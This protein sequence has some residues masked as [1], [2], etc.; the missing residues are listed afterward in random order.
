MTR[1]DVRFISNEEVDT[2]RGLAAGNDGC[3]CAID[4]WRWGMRRNHIRVR[5]MALPPPRNYVGVGMSLGTGF[6]V[7]IGMVVGGAAGDLRSWAGMGIVV[8]AFV[9]FVIGAYFSR[10]QI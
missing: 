10:P 3:V 2:Y 7:A 4:H 6:G 5:A 8:G 9:G 1:L